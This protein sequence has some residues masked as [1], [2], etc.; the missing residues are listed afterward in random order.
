MT[1]LIVVRFFQFSYVFLRDFKENWV[2][3]VKYSCDI[4]WEQILYNTHSTGTKAQENF[5]VNFNIIW[6]AMPQYSPHRIN[7]I[8][9]TAAFEA[10]NLQFL[11]T[12]PIIKI[13]HIVWTISGMVYI[14][15]FLFSERR[16]KWADNR[17]WVEDGL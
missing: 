14:F 16:P 17:I 9:F 5:K 4:P 1:R 15:L 7:D 2:I 12:I 10:T 11:E 13:C 8:A 6:A 3:S